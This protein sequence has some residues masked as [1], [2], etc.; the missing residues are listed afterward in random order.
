MRHRLTRRKGM[1]SSDASAL[2]SIAWSCPCKW[3]C[4]C[5]HA[6]S[7]GRVVFTANNA[8]RLDVQDLGEIQGGYNWGAHASHLVNAGHSNSNSISYGPDDGRGGKAGGALKSA[9]GHKLRKAG[10]RTLPSNSKGR[11]AAAA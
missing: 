7:F 10:S 8:L 3:A 1:T 5:Q 4:G 6:Q 2:N 9:A 11:N